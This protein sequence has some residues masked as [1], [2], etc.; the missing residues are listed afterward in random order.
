MTIHLPKDVESSIVAAVHSGLFA[1]VDEAMDKAARLLL[2]DMEQTRL[3]PGP[4]AKTIKRTKRAQPKKEPLT[5]AQ[6]D[7]HLVEL[8]LMTHIPD[9]AAYVD[10]PDDE[11]IPIR[12]EPL[13]ETVIRERR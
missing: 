8:G 9:T 5:R 6:F 10:D 11:P 3:K 13:S 7:Q 1:S 12:G 4:A 2:R